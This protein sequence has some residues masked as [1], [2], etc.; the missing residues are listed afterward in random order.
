MEIS[1]C[2]NI[3]KIYQLVTDITD[4]RISLNTELQN[5]LL[6]EIS[7]YSP[8]VEETDAAALQIDKISLQ[9]YDND[10]E[11]NVIQH[12]SNLHNPFFMKAME[13]YMPSELCKNDTVDAHTSDT[14]G[15]RVKEDRIHNLYKKYLYI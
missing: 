6:S 10:V 7:K 1:L 15:S 8:S 12:L 4:V 3:Y 2:S 9:E 11:R 13:D 14:C 5:K